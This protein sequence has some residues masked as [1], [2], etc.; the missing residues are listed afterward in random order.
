MKTGPRSSVFGLLVRKERWGL[1]WRGWALFALVALGLL[2][3]GHRFAYPFLALNCPL[4]GEVLVV[5]AWIPVH[6]LHLAAAEFTEGGYRRVLIVRPLYE[7]EKGVVHGR[8]TAEY[9]AT[10]LERCGVPES[11]L[12]IVYFEGSQNDRT[13][14]S[15]LGVKAWF[16]ERGETVTNLDVITVGPHARRSRLLYRK[17]FGAAA[18]VGI[19]ALPDPAYDPRRWWRSSEG[20]REVF[21]ESIAYLYARFFFYPPEAAPPALTE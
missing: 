16:A 18:Q 8:H 7:G 21:S 15:A 4:R 14:H 3:A 1:S 11:S 17:A 19:V 13:Y 6:T 2:L 9:A 12:Q 5:E 20:V 10:V